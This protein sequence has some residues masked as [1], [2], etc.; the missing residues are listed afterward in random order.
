MPDFHIHSETSSDTKMTCKVIIDAAVAAGLK[1]ICI[2]NHH[3][4][5]EVRQGDFRQSLTDEKLDRCRK[6]ISAHTPSGLKVSLGV[7]MGYTESEEDDIREFLDRNKFDFVIGSIHYVKSMVI[8]NPRN[9]GK[10]LDISDKKNKGLFS[11]PTIDEYFRLL[12]KAIAFG[13][14]DVIGH[15]D[16]FK[17]CLDP[18]EFSSL[19]TRWEEVADLL[20]KHDVGFEVNTSREREEPG[21]LYPDKKVIKLFIDKGIRKVTIGS[22]AHKPEDIGRRIDEVKTLL[23][24]YGLKEIFTFEKRRPVPVPL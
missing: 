7:E 3:E 13:Q 2:T 21:G 23:K 17:R 15:A 18:P 10:F 19:K 8:S 20:L 6:D 22:D 16:I 1:H 12:K 9:R 24:S 5:C 14:F 4:P 11:N